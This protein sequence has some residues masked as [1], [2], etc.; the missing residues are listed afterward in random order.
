MELLQLRY[1]IK[2]AEREH[3]TNT[4]KELLISPPSLSA[5]IRKL[6]SEIGVS[7]FER[8]HQRIYLNENG[9]QFYIKVKQVLTILDEC[10][11]D[12]NPEKRLSLS[13]AVTSM[14]VYTT[15]IHDYEQLPNATI[16]LPN[17]VDYEEVITPGYLNQFDFYLGVKEDL[18][19]NE[20]VIL[21]LL[22]P[23]VPIV[24]VSRKDSLAKKTFLTVKDI[25]SRPIVLVSQANSSATNFIKEIFKESHLNPGRFYEGTYPYRQRLISKNEAIGITTVVGVKANMLESP[26]IALI[27]LHET[28]LTRTQSISWSKK[29]K[30]TLTDKLFIH[31]VQSYFKHR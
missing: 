20:R 29:R 2:L 14:A 11:T 28:H 9:K 12:L 27:P 18:D 22:P 24:M 6:E 23:E 15:M 31:F 26:D 7:L 25:Q 16:L 8:K 1:F 17:V 21:P 3:L 10:I 30:L 5:S 19:K 4:A 13:I